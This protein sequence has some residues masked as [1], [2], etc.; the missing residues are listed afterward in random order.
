MR[1]MRDQTLN[2]QLIEDSMPEFMNLTV[3]AKVHKKWL[4]LQDEFF[5][6]NF[7]VLAVCVSEELLK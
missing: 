4:I 3:F 6:F 2:T 7:E 1:Q 5:I